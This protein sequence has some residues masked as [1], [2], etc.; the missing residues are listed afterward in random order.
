M[1]KFY[2]I[3][4]C[5]GAGKTTASF[6]I[7]PRILD[8]QEFVNADEIA[9][10]ISPFHPEKVSIEAGRIMLARIKELF[11][12]KIDF[13]IETTLSSRMYL[14]TLQEAKSLGYESNLLYF[15]LNSPEMAIERVAKRVTQGGHHIPTETIRRRYKQGIKYLFE[16]YA[17]KV[18]NLMVL[19]NSD[20]NPALIAQ[21]T[22]NSALNVIIA[23]KFE[24]IKS[25]A[26]EK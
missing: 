12:K 8:C 4:G 15:W 20:G 24:T 22:I 18:D 19:D 2:I 7:L 10:G 9:R 26:Y 3:A 23:D 17:D 25:I 11:A 13:A 1:P 14:K 16:L 6:K 5:N 21:R